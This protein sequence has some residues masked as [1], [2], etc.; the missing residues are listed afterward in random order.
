[1]ARLNNDAR[2]ILCKMV[3]EKAEAKRKQL[4]DKLTELDDESSES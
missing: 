4:K 3:D 1:M 2:E